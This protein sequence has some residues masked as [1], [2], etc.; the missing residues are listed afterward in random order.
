[1]VAAIIDIIVTVNINYQ[2]ELA[3][4]EA[5]TELGTIAVVAIGWIFDRLVASRF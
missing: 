4:L 5:P 2:V 3:I 1:L